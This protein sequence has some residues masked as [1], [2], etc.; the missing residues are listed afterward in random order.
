LPGRNTLMPHIHRQSHVLSETENFMQILC[1]SLEVETCQVTMGHQHRYTKAGHS[2]PGNSSSFAGSPFF[3]APLT[4]HAFVYIPFFTPFFCALC[5]FVQLFSMR[6]GTK[7]QPLVLLPTMRV[8]TYPEP[9]KCPLA[10]TLRAQNV[11]SGRQP[12]RA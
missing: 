2:K 5:K 3:F 7:R 11:A 6:M 12:T 9:P 1:H 10:T 4:F 8:G